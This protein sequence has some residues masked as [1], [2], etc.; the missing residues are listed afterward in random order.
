MLSHDG[1][2][3]LNSLDGFWHQNR[4]DCIASAD[5]GCGL[6]KLILFAVCSEHDEDWAHE[7]RL[8]FRNSR[9]PR[10]L[11]TLPNS[12]QTGIY[13]LTCSI[14][15]EPT[16][17]TVTIQ[18]FAKKDDAIAEI[19]HQRP[20]RRN[21]GSSNAFAAARALI[22]KCMNPKNPHKH[23]QY[24]R[25]IVLPLRV[26]DVGQPEDLHPTV[27][28]KINDMDTRAQYLAL[29][30]CWGKQPD[31]TPKPLQLLRDNLKQLV[32]GIKFESLQQSIK[33]AIFATRKLGFR[34]LWV[35]ALCIIQDCSADKETEISRMSSIYKNASV[36]IAASSS[37]NA[38]HGFLTQKIRPYCPDYE[39]R[40]PMAN[41]AIGTVYLSTGPYEPD[42]PLDKR[43][44]TL[45]EFMLSSR[46]LIFSDYELLWQCKEVDLRSVS[47][48]GLE[49]LQ[50]LE[51]L[52]WTVFD[53]GAEPFFGHLETDKLYLWKTIVQQYTDRQ[54]TNADDKLNAV[55]GITSELETLWRDI[56]IYGLWKKWFIDL[57]AWY[58]PDIEREKG[59]SLKRAPS[60]SW[61]SLDGVVAYEGSI[62]T[63]DAVVKSLTVQTAVLTCRML[64]IN[65]VNYEKAN[66]IVEGMD[67]ADP[68]AE[69]QEMG[70]TF[71]DL[72][73][74]LLGTVQIGENTKKGKG[75][76]V[77]DVGRGLYRRIGLVNFEDMGIWEGVSR[78]DITFEAKMNN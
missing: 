53:N 78:R 58:K 42:H 23:C 9:V 35:D 64:K 51:S 5:A 17:P 36:T 28:L 74:L 26:L 27:K 24:S 25:D 40:I 70:L 67:L 11:S 6:C 1:L 19:V 2:K 49:Y 69:L 73:Y 38:A 12:Q 60:W 72:E 77:V 20:L 62:S 52:P 8:I 56:N 41:N 76:L 31:N 45:Q 4:T 18:V 21:V 47:T 48:R 44:W 16:K 32:A 33:D 46:M 14:E 43:G 3:S 13:G 66:T 34:Y 68:G 15:S 10:S 30:Y 63:E 39:V 37:E 57:L 29:S 59:R 50:P 75:L 65:E 54:L 71:D 61:A 55:M 7:Q 22:K